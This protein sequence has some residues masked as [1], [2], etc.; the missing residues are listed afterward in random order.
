[1][2]N[3]TINKGWKKNAFILYY[4]LLLGIFFTWHDFQNTPGFGLRLAYFS[5]VAGPL[6]FINKDWTVPIVTLFYIL[7]RENYTSSYLPTELYTY[8]FLLLAISIVRGRNKLFGEIPLVVFILFAITLFCNLFFG[9]F[10]NVT[11]ILFLMILALQT[12]GANDAMTTKYL[13]YSFIVA[14]VVI[15]VYQIQYGE[16]MAVDTWMGTDQIERQGFKDINYT[17]CVIS[18]GVCAAMIN[19]FVEKKLNKIWKLAL[20]SSIPL[21]VYS[22][23]V[24]ASRGSILAV[25]LPAL[26]LLM[27]SKTSL[28]LKIG[29]VLFVVLALFVAYDYGVM[30]Y[31][32]F[33]MENDSTGTGRTEIW[34]R[35]W[36]QYSMSQNAL[37]M[38]FGYGY[39]GGRNLIHR[40]FHNDFLAFLLE[41]GFIGFCCFIAFFFR[42][43]YKI[44]KVNRAITIAAVSALLAVSM[45]LEPFAAG[46][47]PYFAFWLYALGLGKYGCNPIRKSLEKTL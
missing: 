2:S 8:I 31:L 21:M 26:V 23:F 30:D 4:L 46:R 40:A 16:M 28:W 42:P 43:L 27:F 39:E 29:S 37:N 12:G 41:Y 10:E 17:A 32:L 36:N 6:F 22:L 9:T 47:W 3:T 11:G 15:A 45:T 14:G 7:A 25:A 20:V 33:R 24:N 38:L 13:S 1:M 35:A 5:L 18:L 19:I 34:E 44:S